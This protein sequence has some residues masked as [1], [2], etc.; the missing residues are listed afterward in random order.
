VRKNRVDKFAHTGNAQL[1][2]LNVQF[3]SNSSL[4]LYA[5]IEVVFR[6]LNQVNSRV[7]RVMLDLNEGKRKDSRLLLN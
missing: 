5:I 6:K 4:L 3:Y 2:S 7:W 1:S